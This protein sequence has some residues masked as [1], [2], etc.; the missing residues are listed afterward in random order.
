MVFSY[1]RTS[2]EKAE[3]CALLIPMVVLNRN[4]DGFGDIG[5]VSGVK[6]DY[7]EFFLLGV[8][9]YGDDPFIAIY[10]CESLRDIGVYSKE[11]EDVGEYA[12]CLA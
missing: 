11:W 12:S 10:D 5:E 1:F 7:C 9:D 4:E 6:Y 3:E 8:R 2:S